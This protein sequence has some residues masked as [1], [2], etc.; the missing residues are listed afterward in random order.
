MSTITSVKKR[1]EEPRRLGR[2]MPVHSP[3]LG[4]GRV[5]LHVGVRQRRGIVVDRLAG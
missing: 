5:D 4:R 2:V 1:E 3:R